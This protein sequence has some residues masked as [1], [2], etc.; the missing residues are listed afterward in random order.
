MNPL[1]AALSRPRPARMRALL[2]PLATTLAEM[3]LLPM[4]QPAA[5]PPAD[6]ESFSR[7]GWFDSSLELA[8]G[9][10]VIEHLDRLPDDLVIEGLLWPLDDAG[11]AAERRA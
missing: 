1:T 3:A 9:L 6:D 5:A 10:Q 4:E 11:C 2:Q 7:C 8:H